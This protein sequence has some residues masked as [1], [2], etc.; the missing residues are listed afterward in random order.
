LDLRGRKWWESGKDYSEELHNLY[1]SSRLFKPKKDEMV[2]VCNTHKRDEKCVIFLENSKG[3]DHSEDLDVDG[4]VI[5]KCILR[6]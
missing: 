6:K 5:V 4:K 3:R 1:A 2:G